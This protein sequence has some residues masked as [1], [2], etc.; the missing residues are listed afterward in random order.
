MPLPI[1]VDAMGGD[2]APAAIVR[3]ALRAVIEHGIAVTLVGRRE[4]VEAELS[5]TGAGIPDGISVVDAREVI[6]MNEHPA[7]AVRAKRDSSL[8]SSC[9]LVAGGEARGVVSAGNSGAML[10]A[11]LFTIKR[12]PGV[13]RP[14]IG[15]AFPSEAWSD[16]HPGCRRQHRLQAGVARTVRDDG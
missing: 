3:G 4:A 10:A 8:V 2:H 14:A 1:A 11:A 9:A 12:I 16:L 15:A 7:N 13:A 6:E 5:S